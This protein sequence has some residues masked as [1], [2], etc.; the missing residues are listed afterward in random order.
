[1]F[2]W[3]PSRLLLLLM[4]MSFGMLMLLR[5]YLMV[6]LLALNNGMHALQLLLML[7]A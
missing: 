6:L 2:M 3:I 1:M 4:L 7:L 5:G